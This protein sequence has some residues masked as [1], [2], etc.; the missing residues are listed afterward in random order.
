M[1]TAR[2]IAASVRAGKLPASAAVMRSLDALTADP[3]VAVTRVLAQRAMAEAAA[4]DAAAALGKD[5]GPLAGVPFA[6]KD[7]FDVA[8]LPT[9]AGSAVRAQAAPARDNAD[10]VQL[11]AIDA[12]APDAPVTVLP[13]IKRAR[14]AAFVITAYE[15]GHLHRAALAENAMAFD[16]AVRDRLLA[17]ALLPDALYER[18]L[19]FRVEFVARVLAL[20]ADFD[21]L[22]APAVRRAADRRSADHDRRRVAPGARGPWHSYPAD[23]VYRPARAGGAAAPARRA[24]AV[25]G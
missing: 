21:V 11:V 7:L 3:H 24:A 20:L 18:A 17:G 9:T 5:P 12:I 1:M 16:P 2:A 6:V 14:R 4:V 23:H 19:A 22:L 10:P 15:G 13:D 25:G 8:G